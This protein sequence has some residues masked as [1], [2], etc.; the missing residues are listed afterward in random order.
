MVEIDCKTWM[1]IRNAT[2]TEKRLQ[3]GLDDLRVRLVTASLVFSAAPRVPQNILAP[4]NITLDQSPFT[5]ITHVVK[6][7]CRKR[8]G[9]DNFGSQELWDR[10]NLE[11]WL[12]A[13]GQDLCHAIWNTLSHAMT[14]LERVQSMYLFSTCAFGVRTLST[15]SSDT[16]TYLTTDRTFCLLIDIISV[17]CNRAPGLC[18]SVSTPPD[19]YVDGVTETFIISEHH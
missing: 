18:M 2:K 10:S 15:F 1:E 12:L 8:P 3:F 9:M 14:T 7:D 11:N 16:L 6:S 17:S 5:T 13:R 4:L 19:V